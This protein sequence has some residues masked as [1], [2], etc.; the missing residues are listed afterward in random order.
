MTTEKD[1]GFEAWLREAILGDAAVQLALIRLLVRK[2][3]Q[4][5]LF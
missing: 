5:S 1:K 3:L 2:G 4:N